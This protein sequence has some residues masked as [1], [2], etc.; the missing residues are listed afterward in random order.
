MDNKQWTIL[1]NGLL[2]EVHSLLSPLANVDWTREVNRRA[3]GILSRR[4]AELMVELQLPPV[5]RDHKLIAHMW[6]RPV[7]QEDGSTKNVMKISVYHK[8]VRGNTARGKTTSPQRK[9]AAPLKSE[10]PL[11]VV[12]RAKR[13]I[14]RNGYDYVMNRLEC[15]M[16]TLMEDPITLKPVE[17]PA[18]PAHAEDQEAT[19]HA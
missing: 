18:N 13:I 19:L 4:A 8:R 17:R 3:D 10:D 6:F 5:P 14:E 7:R 15:T 1:K 9:L 2:A 12:S 11:S 16:D